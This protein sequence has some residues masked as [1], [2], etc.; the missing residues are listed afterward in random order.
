M[1]F[2]EN[3][4]DQQRSVCVNRLRKMLRFGL[5]FS[6]IQQLRLKLA[7]WM[8][9]P[10]W[11]TLLLFMFK[12]CFQDCHLAWKTSTKM[13]WNK[14]VPRI[15]DHTSYINQ[16]WKNLKRKETCLHLEANSTIMKEDWALAKIKVHS[17]KSFITD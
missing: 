6:F 2:N 1:R 5:D 11:W 14:L 17:L 3:C 4:L 8:W 7:M 13:F 15:Y 12:H 10:F 9:L 16:R